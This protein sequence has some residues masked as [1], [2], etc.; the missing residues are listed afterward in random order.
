MVYCSDWSVLRC[1]RRLCAGPA[2]WMLRLASRPGWR[3]RGVGVP[4][5]TGSGGP[6]PWYV[7]VP[8]WLSGL[9]GPVAI[10][11]AVIA[12]VTWRRSGFTTQNKAT[13]DHLRRA[14]RVEIANTGRMDAAVD[15]IRLWEKTPITDLLIPT[16]NAT[17]RDVKVV[18]GIYVLELNKPL[19]EWIPVGLPP[20]RTLHATLTAGPPIA[21]KGKPGPPQLPPLSVNLRRH[22]IRVV[23][24]NGTM[25]NLRISESVLDAYERSKIGILADLGTRPPRWRPKRM[26]SISHKIP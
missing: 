5:L 23:F 24:G 9:S 20:G 12:Y 17:R 18:E 4:L 2:C 11:A 21:A 19:A 10:A 26:R 16:P 22:R 6:S 7:W 25:S 8:A 13:I 1:H 15:S 3:W 14:I